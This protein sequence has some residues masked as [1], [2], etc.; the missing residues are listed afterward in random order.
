MSEFERRR[1]N[2][3]W[4]GTDW[5]SCR[6]RGRGL[7]RKS[8]GWP[9]ERENAGGRGETVSFVTPF[10]QFC[11]AQLAQFTWTR[12]GG[13]PR[14]VGAASGANVGGHSNTAAVTPSADEPPVVVM[15]AQVGVEERLAE[16]QDLQA[17]GLITQEEASVKRAD[18]LA[19]L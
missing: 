7:G 15:A 5:W 6:S 1:L 2:G 13:G 18:I 10:V 12:T 4:G 11:S 19:T 3:G 16:V 9:H 14:D 8:I 17:K